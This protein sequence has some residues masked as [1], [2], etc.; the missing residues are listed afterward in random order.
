M[1]IYYVFQVER[2]HIIWYAV[3]VEG[4]NDYLI[5][6]SGMTLIYSVWHML[7]RPCMNHREVGTEGKVQRYFGKVHRKVGTEGKVQ[8]V[9][10]F[11]GTVLH[12]DLLIG[13]SIG[14]YIF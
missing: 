7:S 5:F 2:S 8:I 9:Y 1:F 4:N 10:L 13:F 14:D 12:H 6:G 3:Q 11:L